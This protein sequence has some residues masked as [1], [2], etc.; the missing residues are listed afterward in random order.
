MAGKLKGL[1]PKAMLIE[2]GEKAVFGIAGL[3]VLLAI[4]GTDWTAY[5]GK[6]SDITKKVVDARQVLQQQ[7]WDGEER[8][9]YILPA[10]QQPDAVIDRL[11]SPN[12][13]PDRFAFSTRISQTPWDEKEPLRDPVMLALQ[14]PIADDGR[15]LIHLAP[16]GT[17]LAST[18]SEE[19]EE[20]EDPMADMLDDENLPD[21]FRRRDRGLTAGG[22]G[23]EY[24]SMMAGEYEAFAPELEEYG[25][26]EDMAMMAGEYGEE[27]GEYGEGSMMGGAAGPKL[28]GKG[29]PYVSV[30][31]VFP[32][33]EQIRKYADAIHRPPFEAASKFE[34]LDFELQRQTKLD[35]GSW[36]EWADVDI[37]VAKDILA[38]A[39]GY[40]PEVVAST[41]TDSAM[42]MPLPA[43]ITGVWRKLATHPAIEKFEL[44]E[45]QI[46]QEL[47]L[48]KRL[49]SKFLEERAAQSDAPVEKKG[50]ADLV[51]NTRHVQSALMGEES[52]YGGNMYEMAGYDEEEMYSGGPG[53]GVPGG[54]GGAANTPFS[55]LVEELTA[56]EDTKEQTE[57]LRKAII[58]RVTV[59]G[60]LLLFRYIDF[61]VEPGKTYR[62]QAKLWLRNPNYGRRIAEAG[63]LPHVVQGVDRPTPW[64]KPTN[65]V[66]VRETTNYFVQRVEDHRGRQHKVARMS[67]YQWDPE[68]GALVRDNVDVTVGQMIGGTARPLV[69]KPAE[70][71]FEEEEYTFQ[72]DDLLVDVVDDDRINPSDHPHL[73]LQ[74]TK[75]DL[76]I[77]EKALVADADGTLRVLS[78]KDKDHGRARSLA[79][80]YYTLQEEAFEHL[81]GKMAASEEMMSELGEYGEYS[82]MYSGM[83]GEG[84]EESM[85]RGRR[86][87]NVM[88]KQTRSRGGRSQM[89]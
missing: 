2:H 62:Y 73:K 52:A 1:D 20:A 28:D 72:S 55:K 39:A 81:K 60:E 83:Y 80:R 79:E 75:G 6:P 13:S 29:Y 42:T 65:P 32:Y 10:D 9:P 46:Q 47:E 19:T 23:G 34:I 35:D 56:T 33:R 86:G 8:E 4:V 59:E 58:E 38:S 53:Y 57:K 3:L 64:S 51:F 17:D 45:E 37:Q 5:D 66:T 7:K 67:L 89:P 69:L 74:S 87:R 24:G 70:S 15:V 85:G 27:Y 21:E 12:I 43:R 54:R 82:E 36:S 44:T 41:V 25:S 11:I 49:L 16:T 26:P 22:A 76:G 77:P 78:P 48:N 88:R 40:D 61:D 31:A 68:F 50:F 63:G 18:E 30:R 71:T 84:A 14:Q